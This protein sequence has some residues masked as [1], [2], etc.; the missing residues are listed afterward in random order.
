MHIGTKNMG[1][2]I[3]NLHGHDLEK[4]SE[5]KDREITIYC[6]LDFDTHICEKVKKANQ[7]FGL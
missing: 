3:Y 6:K 5:E 2:Y 4:I 7:M 1:D